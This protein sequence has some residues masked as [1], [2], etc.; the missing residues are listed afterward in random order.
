VAF[1]GATTDRAAAAYVLVGAPLDV[2]ATFRPGARFGPDRIR[3]FARGF[4]DYDHRTGGRFSDRAVHD[5]G[6]VPAWDDAAAYLDH[7]A[8]ELRAIRLD[9]ALALVLGG[10][11][12]VTWAGVRATAPDTLLA[13]DAHLDLRERFDDNPLSHAC[14]LRRAL[15]GGDGDHPTVD[16][17]IVVGARTGSEAEWERAAR[18]DVTV[19]PPESAAGWVERADPT[20]WGRTYLSVDVDGADP[21]VAPATG[22]PEPFGLAA[23]T[24]RDVVRLAAP[25][26]VAADAVE[27]T[28]DDGGRTAGLAAK[29]LR[30]FVH[31]HAHADADAG[32]A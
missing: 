26:T 20:G 14:V 23:R 4:D 2:S 29:L 5:A 24:V 16:R 28:D 30:E 21:S 13:V 12:T 27:V 17:L 10:E 32:D 19:V 25:V 18:P 31:A 1:P 22:T 3:R 11:H 8:A 15:D 9:D 6:D 7:L